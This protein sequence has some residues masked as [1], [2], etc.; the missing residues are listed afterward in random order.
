MILLPKRPPSVIHLHSQSV[1]IE[2]S[3]IPAGDTSCCSRAEHRRAS[4]TRWDGPPG[5]GP[6]VPGTVERKRTE[7]DSVMSGQLLN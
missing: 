2:P 4:N 7:S 3:K 6:K 1:T 5:G